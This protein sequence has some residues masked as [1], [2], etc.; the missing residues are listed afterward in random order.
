M[1]GKLVQLRGKKAEAGYEVVYGIDKSIDGRYGLTFGSISFGSENETTTYIYGGYII[2]DKT[3]GYKNVLIFNGEL[4][5]S[6]KEKYLLVVIPYAAQLKT[7]SKKIAGRYYYEA[8]LEMH[9]GDTVE[10]SKNSVGKRD[11]YMAV[12]AGNEMF[13]IKKERWFTHIL[14]V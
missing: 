12:Q 13:L 14:Y 7:N 6:D 8:I 3:D 1:F 5:S 10:V 9:N 2:E 11:V 4:E